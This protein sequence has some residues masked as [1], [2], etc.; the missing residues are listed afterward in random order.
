MK[1][2]IL[3]SSIT[4]VVLGIALSGC[5]SGANS[6]GIANGGA[7]GQAVPASF[8]ISDTPPQGVSI[9]RFQIQV[10]A[11]ALQPSSNSQ[12]PVSMLP[13]PATVELI[14]LQSESALLA[15]F[16]VPAGT[17]SSLMVT[18][19]NPQMTIL[20][21][22]NT[23]Y[24]VGGV[25]CQPTQVCT[26]TPTLNQ[27]MVT[28][29]A[30]PFPITL[31]SSSPVAFVLHFDV[32][33][34]VQGDLSVSPTISLKE[35]PP[36]P[37][38]ALEQFHVIGRITGVNT[39]NSTFTLQTGF[40]NFSLTIS[41][42]SSTQYDFGSVCAADT[43][44]CLMKGEVVRVE[45]S[46]MPGGALVATNVEL[47]APQ[48]QPVLEGVVIGVNTAKNEVQLVLIDFQDDAQGHL[49]NAK[50]AYGLPL[51]V[52]LSS[53]TTFSIDTDG[54]T[55]PSTGPALSFASVN[56]MIVGQSLAVQPVIS[57][58]QFS[59]TPPS[60]QI[61]FTASN[62]QLESS[63]LTATVD[64]VNPPSFTLDQLPPLFTGATPAI[65]ELDVETVAG[66][67]FENIAGVSALAGGDK[68]S[69]GGLL[70]NTASV[71]TLVAERVLLR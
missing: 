29:E 55:L 30:A 64:T 60:I 10:M 12:Q 18:F 4:I 69:V 42:N 59:G 20:N 70:F 62:V 24:T 57:S 26:L 68:V 19:A 46:G 38:G 44:S 5:G 15:N 16:S 23:E 35:L 27:S 50:M 2:I 33:A 53:T 65:S 45:L 40:G 51:T 66:T 41:T 3:I 21:Q 17:Y 25:T 36:L 43:F 7:S 39:Q 61:T 13:A 8:S 47:I 22:S 1:R 28:D 52:Q 58:I 54:I 32:N 37:S 31:S 9:L 48:F 34:S 71:P 56:D 49:G 11:A 67:N 6:A 14:H 63:E